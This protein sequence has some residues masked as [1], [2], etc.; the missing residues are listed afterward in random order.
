MTETP[1]TPTT[2]VSYG[3]YPS[4]RPAAPI[5]KPETY[6]QFE[7]SIKSPDAFDALDNF[8]NRGSEKGQR[9]AL[10]KIIDV[11]IAVAHACSPVCPLLIAQFSSAVE[12]CQGQW[13]YLIAAHD[14]RPAGPKA[15]HPG[16]FPDDT[17]AFR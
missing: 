12:Y 9:W 7:A 5:K 8:Y 10:G 4:A 17:R 11:R 13:R 2:D 16:R 14:C 15:T 3:K 6:L 1:W